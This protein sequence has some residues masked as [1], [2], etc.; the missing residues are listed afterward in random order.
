L[1]VK[2]ARNGTDGCDEDDDEGE[3][4]SPTPGPHLTMNRENIIVERLSLPSPAGRGR[5]A[6]R[7]FD[8]PNG[9]SG[10]YQVQEPIDKFSEFRR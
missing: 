3:D 5:I 4:G 6:V 10:T 7:W 1:N 9:G 8:T 2:T